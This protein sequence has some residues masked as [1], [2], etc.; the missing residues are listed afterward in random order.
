MVG[1]SVVADARRQFSVD[2]IKT[3]L[4]MARRK[5]TIECFNVDQLSQFSVAPAKAGA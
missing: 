5:K 4:V 1:I 2:G 3:G